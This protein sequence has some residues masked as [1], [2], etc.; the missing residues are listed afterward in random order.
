MLFLCIFLAVTCVK[1]KV[2]HR[3]FILLLQDRTSNHAESSHRRLQNQ[4]TMAHPTIWKFIDGLKV[5]QKSREADHESIIAG[6]EPPYKKKRNIKMLTKEFPPLSANLLAM[7]PTILR[8]QCFLRGI[9]SFFEAFRDFLRGISHNY[10][11][12]P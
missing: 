10:Q 8:S 1:I 4:L 5:A 11:I 3:N 6:Y 7:I 2:W 12:N 9:L